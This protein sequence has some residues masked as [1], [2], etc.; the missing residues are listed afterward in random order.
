MSVAVVSP[1]MNELFERLL[2]AVP[3]EN[4][5]ILEKTGITLAQ[6][7]RAAAEKLEREIAAVGMFATT[8]EMSRELDR[9]LSIAADHR[10]S[11]D[12]LD[13]CESDIVQWRLKES[14]TALPMLLEV[15]D[16]MIDAFVN[17]EEHQIFIRLSEVEFVAF[18]GLVA[19]S[20][21]IWIKDAEHAFRWK[22]LS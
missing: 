7:Y 22:I 20:P 5:P 9:K 2:A 8:E 13:L 18:T 16:E 1:V 12:M 4:L 17:M 21:R 15:D 6:A 3:A 14:S 10:S 11:A 19:H